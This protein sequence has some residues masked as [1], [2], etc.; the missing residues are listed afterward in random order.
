MLLDR[1]LVQGRA[2]G[3][4]RVGGGAG[5]GRGEPGLGVG[6][7]GEEGRGEQGGCLSLKR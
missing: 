7:G 6:G 2:G 4:V 3:Y 5:G 1:K